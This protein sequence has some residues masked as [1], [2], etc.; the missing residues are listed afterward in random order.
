M[1]GMA[2]RDDHESFPP[3]ISLFDVAATQR[4]LDLSIFRRVESVL[5][6]LGSPDDGALRTQV[7]DS[8][9]WV[10]LRKRRPRGFGCSASIC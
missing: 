8:A 9:A 6:V 7:H 5:A 3:V 4:L 1:A 10:K 2:G